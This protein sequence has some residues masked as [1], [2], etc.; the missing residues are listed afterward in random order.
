MKIETTA[1]VLQA[2]GRPLEERHF[3]VD[4]DPHYIVVRIAAAGVCG[5]DVHMFHGKDDRVPFPII[6][7]H[8]GVGILEYLPD[9]LVDITGKPLSSGDLVIWNRGLSCG[10][11]Y[12][13]AVKK[14]PSLCPNRKAYGI[15][16][17]CK[18]YPHL[19]GCYARHIVIAPGTDFIKLDQAV[20][21]DPAIMVAAACSGAT[22][23]HAFELVRPDM[24][25]TV[26]V[27][28]PGPLGIFACA[29]ARAY[30]AE[31]VI[32]IGGTDSRLELCRHV[33]AITLNRNK[34]TEGERRDFIR[35]FTDGR[36][37]DM[38]VETVGT[39]AAVREGLS[40]V[41]QGGAYLSAGF[42]APGGLVEIDPFGDITRRNI[43]YQGVW[44]SDTRHVFDA[45]SLVKKM[46][47]FFIKLVTHRFPLSEAN[48]ALAAMEH[49]EVI[50]A[51]LIP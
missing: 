7:G 25:D 35:R 18:D 36:G 3:E 20:V 40:L 22:V 24:G 42:G 9:G 46:P 12:F 6:L 47:E 50:K 32:V 44:V 48:A 8:E 31:N 34:T 27:Q 10:H 43:R 1:M 2:P 49:R 51:V 23:A 45:V 26:V 4:V 15:N 14:I 38:V 21:N 41:R 39:A 16:M 19:S 11:C 30:G 37:A 17:S 13:C 33:G 5:S 28:G 29:F